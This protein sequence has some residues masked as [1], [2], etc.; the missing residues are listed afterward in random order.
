MKHRYVTYLLALLT[1]GAVLILA[2]CDP[3]GA[4]KSASGSGQP[5]GS[6]DEINAFL[7]ELYT[8]ASEQF[9]STVEAFTEAIGTRINLGAAAET[10]DIDIKKLAEAMGKP[11]S[12][13]SAAK[14]L[15]IPIEKLREAL[16]FLEEAGFEQ[17]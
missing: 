12:L 4:E 7:T 17:R 6:T 15:E 1:A 10:L 3:A 9:D 16:P 8:R 11:P 2:A 14:K 5:G 13:E